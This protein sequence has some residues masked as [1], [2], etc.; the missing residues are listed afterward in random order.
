MSIRRGITPPVV[1][2]RRSI[3]DVLAAGVSRMFITSRSPKRI[4]SSMLAALAGDIASASV[5]SSPSDEAEMEEMLQHVLP[6]VDQNDPHTLDELVRE[7]EEH[8]AEQEEQERVEA[9]EREMERKRR[10]EMRK[11]RIT[12]LAMHMLRYNLSIRQMQ[13]NVAINAEILGTT[14]LVLRIAVLHIR[15]MQAIRGNQRAMQHLI[16]HHPAYDGEV[17]SI[18]PRAMQILNAWCLHN[19]SATPTVEELG[20][21]VNGLAARLELQPKTVWFWLRAHFS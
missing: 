8:A 5:G 20:A 19:N 21:V 4:T 14:V 3:N 17:P 16:Q 6:G 11:A 18:T 2:S 7:T 12:E 13:T 9:Q 10:V 1:S 15:N